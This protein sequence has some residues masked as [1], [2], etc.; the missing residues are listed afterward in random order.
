MCY[1]LDTKANPSKSPILSISIELTSQA[2]EHD[3]LEVLAFFIILDFSYRKEGKNE[4]LTNLATDRQPIS[5]CFNPAYANCID[6]I[7]V[8]IGAGFTS[9]RFG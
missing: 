5:I 6:D 2:S 7:E 3:P 4:T 9:S 8:R 1:Y